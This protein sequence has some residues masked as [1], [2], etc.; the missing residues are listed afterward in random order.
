MKVLLLRVPG[1]KEIR[2]PLGISLT[3]GIG[4]IASF[5]RENGYEV[6][7]LDTYIEGW[8]C[9]E[10]VQEI[11][12]ETYDII[13]FTITF[14]DMLPHFAEVSK[15]LRAGGVKAHFTMGGHYPSFSCE[16]MLLAFEQLDSVCLFESEQTFLELVKCIE[17]KMDIS[18]LKGIA[19]RK[20]G[21]IV[22]NE[23]RALVE[24]LDMLPFPDRS[25]MKGKHKQHINATIL[26]SRGCY[27]NCSFC[28]VNQFYTIP[29]GAK[30]RGRSA[31]NV[32]D[33]LEI[34]NKEYG[35]KNFAFI[36]DNFFGPGN[37]GRS[38]IMDF[39][40]ELEQRD[41]K[42]A[43]TASARVNDGNETIYRRLKEVGLI[44]VF[45]GVESGNNSS[46]KLF[47]KQIEAD[48]NYEAIQLLSEIG[49]VSHVGLILFEPLLTYDCL[50]QNLTFLDSIKNFVPL[51][52]LEFGKLDVLKGSPIEKELLS[53]GIIKEEYFS[54]EKGY[55][56]DFVDKDVALFS[57]LIDRIGTECNN[58]EAFVFSRII[59]LFNKLN[60]MEYLKIH[61]DTVTIKQLLRK[62]MLES[63]TA[64]LRIIGE[65]YEAISEGIAEEQWGQMVSNAVQSIEK[66]NHKTLKSLNILEKLLA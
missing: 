59:N 12:K 57:T 4:Y 40:D 50:G 30:W 25:Y 52:V 45:L 53:M 32:V 51:T 63:N 43:F 41:L 54:Y 65:S 8:G 24:D 58:S 37:K 28:S 36:D 11:L 49:L 39:C 7:I 46:L 55:K 16:E 23:P 6:Q 9:E 29:Q 13:G 22:I 2:T 42:I 14:R 31:K 64:L 5:L 66:K 15:R 17:N 62:I 26:T 38:R 60:K 61:K 33:E 56:Y 27:G 19:S 20:D 21:R 35:V 44:G 10:T 48:K 3:L 47:N 18:G 1:S 34:L